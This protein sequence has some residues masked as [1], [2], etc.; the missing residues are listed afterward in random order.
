MQNNVVAI[1]I[2]IDWEDIKSH[3]ETL[4]CCGVIVNTQPVLH[5]RWCIDMSSCGGYDCDM[6]KA[7][8]FSDKICLWSL[9]IFMMLSVAAPLILQNSTTRL[10]CSKWLRKRR[11]ITYTH[12]SSQTCIQQ[13]VMHLVNHS[14]SSIFL[15]KR[16]IVNEFCTVLYIRIACG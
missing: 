2:V 4:K 3:F 5:A 12:T 15:T 1:S 14:M 8:P 7:L 11:E 16:S 9:C 6:Y 10:L 13:H